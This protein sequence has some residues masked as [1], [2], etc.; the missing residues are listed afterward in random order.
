MIPF[1]DDVHIYDMI[2]IFQTQY[3][4]TR[5]QVKTRMFKRD[6]PC[7]RQWTNRNAEG[8]FLTVRHT[9]PKGC[10]RLASGGMEN[11]HLDEILWEVKVTGAF[12]CFINKQ[13][14]YCILYL[15]L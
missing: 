2:V 15:A 9:S 11:R 12:E 6:S 4:P 3:F 5:Q 1:E 7:I 14:L 8:F 10:G 13:K